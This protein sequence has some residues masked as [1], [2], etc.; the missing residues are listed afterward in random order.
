MGKT[1]VNSI[2]V[3]RPYIICFFKFKNSIGAVVPVS[4]VIII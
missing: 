1:I 2:A 4:F 3:V